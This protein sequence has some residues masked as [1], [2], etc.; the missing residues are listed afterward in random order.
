MGMYIEVPISEGRLETVRAIIGVWWVDVSKQGY[1]DPTC[2][3]ILVA[4]EIYRH[5]SPEWCAVI[6]PLECIRMTIASPSL[7]ENR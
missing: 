3:P 5:P 7:R 2:G 4:K 1:V 6:P